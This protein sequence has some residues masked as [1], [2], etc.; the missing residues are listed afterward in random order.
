VLS[1]KEIMAWT[2]PR[3]GAGHNKRCSI[4]RGCER[5]MGSF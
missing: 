3:G 5:F 2:H 1:T 4:R